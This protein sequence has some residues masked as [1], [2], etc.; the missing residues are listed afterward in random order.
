M[1]QVWEPGAPH[2][3][4]EMWDSTDPRN[5]TKT[6]SRPQTCSRGG[7]RTLAQDEVLGTERHSDHRPVGAEHSGSGEREICFFSELQCAFCEEFLSLSAQ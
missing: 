7:A 1:V 6:G 5:G 3:D 4:S 2:L